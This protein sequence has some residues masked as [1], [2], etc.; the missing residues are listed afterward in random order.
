MDAAQPYHLQQYC[1]ELTAQF[2]PM[3]AR[4]KLS[5]IRRFCATL[6][7]LGHMTT[8]PAA[9]VRITL[10]GYQPRAHYLPSLDVL[11]EIPSTTILGARDSAIL[12]LRSVGMLPPQIAA[13]DMPD[14]D[15]AIQAVWLR[16]RTGK[17]HIQLLDQE[18]SLHFDAGGPSDSDL[19]RM[20]L[21]YSSHF[22][23][24][25][26]DHDLTAVSVDVA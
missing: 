22:T 13:L 21:P 3:T 10:K 2:R 4:R 18:T 8:N 23:G 5:A 15:S 9:K 19:A 26:G 6:N 7:E 17:R 14:I 1:A 16:G 24:L 11:A 12:M 25:L 20:R